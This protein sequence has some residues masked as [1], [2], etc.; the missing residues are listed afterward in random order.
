MYCIAHT[1]GGRK[2]WWIMAKIFLGEK[3]LAHWLFCT[4]LQGWR[5]LGVAHLQLCSKIGQL[6]Y[7]PKITILCYVLVYINFHLL[8]LILSSCVR[9][10]LL[11][12]DCFIRV[13]ITTR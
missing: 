5:N 6:G 10:V 1:F 11:K 12:L 13:Y 2:L 3:I 4:I 7:F 8:C 9:F